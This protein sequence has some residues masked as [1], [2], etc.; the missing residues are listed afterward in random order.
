MHKVVDTQEINGQ[1]RWCIIKSHSSWSWQLSIERENGEL[2]AS[3]FQG[4]PWLE[5]WLRA[6]GRLW[7]CGAGKSVCGLSEAGVLGLATQNPE[8]SLDL[9]NWWHLLYRF[10][11]LSGGLVVC[12]AE[13][14]SKTPGPMR[15]GDVQDIQGNPLP[16]RTPNLPS[17]KQPAARRQQPCLSA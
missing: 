14:D 7:G 4:N 10:T 2:E 13:L 5:L 17:K 9:P 16:H 8:F 3:R 1:L 6:G 11:K 15:R 12:K